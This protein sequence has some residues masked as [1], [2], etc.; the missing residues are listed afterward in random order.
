MKVC[1][2]FTFDAAHY[3]L[4]DKGSPCEEPHGHT[5]KLEIVID[6]PVGEDGMV[7]DFTE[8]KR[9][10]NEKIMPQIDHKNLNELIENPTA[11]NIA[12]WIFDALKSHMNV[13]SVKVWEGEGKWAETQ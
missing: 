8:I 2:E 4:D 10:V 7:M 12:L 3:I 11:E 5:Y 1:R 13:A 6:G 9:I